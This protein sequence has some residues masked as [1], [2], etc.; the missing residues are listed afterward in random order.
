MLLSTWRSMNP[1][2]PVGMQNGMATEEEM[3]AS[4]KTKYILRVQH[5]NHTPGVCSRVEIHDHVYSSTRK[6]AK[7][8]FKISRPS[9]PASHSLVSE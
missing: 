2:I 9:I 6:M 4:Y 3:V 1:V 5:N 8:A 7:V